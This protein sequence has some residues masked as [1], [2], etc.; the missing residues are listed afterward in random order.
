MPH[1]RWPDPPAGRAGQGVAWFVELAP[2]VEAAPG[3][4]AVGARVEV[5]SRPGAGTRVAVGWCEAESRA[6][7]D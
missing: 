5:E 4:A 1:G 2:M 6:K 3:A 7:E